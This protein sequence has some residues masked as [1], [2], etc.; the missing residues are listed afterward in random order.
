MQ[1]SVDRLVPPS[2][3][4]PI[5]N[6]AN[7]EIHNHY[8]FSNTEILLANQISVKAGRKRE[9]VSGRAP[10][11]CRPDFPVS[12]ILD[13][14]PMVSRSFIGFANAFKVSRFA[15]CFVIYPKSISPPPL[16]IDFEKSSDRLF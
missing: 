14:H 5:A 15:L 12:I 1:A 3:F 9:Q 8:S 13:A 16:A 7:S 2:P 11:C 4:V 10:T 6:V